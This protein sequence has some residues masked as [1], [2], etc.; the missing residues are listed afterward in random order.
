MS[1]FGN[2]Y[3]DDQ[4]DPQQ[5]QQSFIGPLLNHNYSSSSR[6]MRKPT[7]KRS[8]YGFVGLLNQG[9]TCYLNS[10][11]QML[12]LTPELKNELYTMSLEEF[13]IEKNSTPAPTNSTKPSDVIDT[14]TVVSTLHTNNN[15]NKNNNEASVINELKNVLS[16]KLNCGDSV[17]NKIFSHILDNLNEGDQST[18]SATPLTT[19]TTSTAATG[20]DNT[21]TTS[22]TLDEELLSTEYAES[23]LAFG[24]ERYKVLEEVYTQNMD[25]GCFD[26]FAPFNFDTPSTPPPSTSTT[27]TTTT[28]NTNNFSEQNEH[29]SR[30]IVLYDENQSK[31]IFFGPMNNPE[32]DN[33]ETT[34]TSNSNI[35][36]NVGTSKPKRKG[37]VISYELQR[38]FALLQDGN[39]F[40]LSTEDLTKSFG[41][42][43]NEAV[44]QQDIHEL[45]RI[46]F[47][48]IEHS[49]KNTKIEDLFNRLYRGVSIVRIECSKCGTIRDREESFQD[50]PITVKGFSSLEDSLKAYV[51]PEILDNENKYSCETCKERVVAT[52]GNKLGKLPPVLILPLNRFDYDFERDTRVKLHNKFEFPQVLD[53]TPYTSGYSLHEKDP[54]KYPKPDESKYELF[55]VV[56]HS[57]GAYGG[58]YHSFIKDVSNI[59]V[60]VPQKPSSQTESTLDQTTSKS[61]NTLTTTTTI[62]NDNTT[63]SIEN[64]NI[65]STSE[66]IKNDSGSNVTTSTTTTNEAKEKDDEDDVYSGWFDFNDSVVT[67]IKNNSIKKQFG[68]KDE[69]AYMLVYRDIN[70]KKKVVNQSIPNH[71]KDEIERFNIDLENQRLLYDSSVNSMFIYPKF[72]DSFE[73]RGDSLYEKEQSVKEQGEDTA[74]LKL[75][76]SD[77]L[78]DMVTAIKQKYQDKISKLGSKIVIQEITIRDGK[79][80]LHPPINNTSSVNI[81]KAGIREGSQLL[82]WNGEENSGLPA[83]PIK[84]SVQCYTV[85]EATN[86]FEDPT[87]SSPKNHEVL[88]SRDSKFGDLQRQLSDR[89]KIPLES[90][91][92]YSTMGHSL[93]QMED[94]IDTHISNRIFNGLVLMI[95]Q[96]NEN[97]SSI[98]KQQFEL[99][100]NKIQI[101]VKDRFDTLINAK[102]ITPIKIYCDPKITVYQLKNI[103]FDAIR[104]DQKEKWIDQTIL[105]KTIV[106]GYDGSAI[107]DDSLI[108]KEA[109]IVE[110]SL[111]ILEKGTPT[112]STLCV[113]YLY[114]IDKIVIT[115]EPKVLNISK[116]Q[117]ILNMKI[118]MLRQLGINVELYGRYI[119]KFTDVFEKPTNILVDEDQTLEE[120]GLRS[121]E[122]LWLEEGVL[123]SRDQI[124]LSFNFYKCKDNFGLLPVPSS[125]ILHLNPQYICPISDLYTI[126]PIGSLFVERKHQLSVVKDQISKWD[127]F[128][129]ETRFNSEEDDFRIWLDEKLLTTSQSNSKQISKLH[130]QS[131]AT[132]TIELFKKNQ[133]IKTANQQQNNN[134]NNNSNEPSTSHCPPILLY[135]HKRKPQ[136]QSFEH[137]PQQIS[138]SG[139]SLSQIT[140][141]ISL[142]YEIDEQFIKVFKFFPN[143]IINPWRLIEQKNDTNNND[144]NSDTSSNNSE[145][146][147]NTSTPPLESNC[148][149]TINQSSI[150]SSNDVETSNTNIPPPPP[151]PLKKKK[152]TNQPNP[153]ELRGKP[154]LLKDGDIISF[155]DT[156]DDPEGNDKFAMSLSKF[157]NKKGSNNHSKNRTPTRY[158]A[159]EA[160]LKIQLDDY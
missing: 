69:C 152:A 52:Y 63:V 32:L 102:D 65:T 142:A 71:F 62:T 149:S 70:L 158:K 106:G 3:D 108:L 60:S 34:T 56:I 45:N 133:V 59:G 47:D 96:K 109:N 26:A 117:S 33:S 112:K 98:I 20:I 100:K 90:L 138:F 147:S 159:P 127:K 17:K 43:D 77:T 57:G 103:I 105:R 126:T 144:N 88:V 18:S 146:I 87:I 15:N 22:S 99:N 122:L 30:A 115:V 153:S 118:E 140:N 76:V 85:T 82:I 94:D 141:C 50:I 66:S 25:D 107:T 156:R 154:Y 92:I 38:L 12:Y 73:V 120:F 40:A 4:D 121:Y 53:M 6:Y 157:D 119:I 41:W 8:D 37:R 21:T 84:I 11:I 104:P 13:G 132:L 110:Y 1:L 29:S 131:E 116:T 83:P 44:H 61:E 97:G 136:E 19:T 27:T 58:H 79:V 23:V 16:V 86:I 51:T 129:K 113:R 114:A 160:E 130:I 14:D 91:V 93:I 64:I 36:N 123:P 55:G 28:T 54:L 72:L 42:N 24:F 135:I 74:T 95:E 48:A 124:Q 46:L 81:K 9:A 150:D 68:G 151:P 101:F 80:S 49:I 35:N 148:N 67:P 134:I 125:P 155:L 145:V 89:F 75:A 39:V 2:L 78:F 139:K 128:R 31:N 143:Q 111:L 5:H 7:E 137:P 10:L